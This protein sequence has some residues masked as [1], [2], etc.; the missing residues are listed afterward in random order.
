MTLLCVPIMVQDAPSALDEAQRAKQAGADIIEL[1]VDQVF[2]GSGDEAEFGRIADLVGACPMPVIVTCRS[3]SEGGMYDGPDDARL[4]L[5]EFLGT[6]E[7]RTS[8]GTGSR[9]DRTRHPPR[10]VDVEFAA[11]ERSA[12][13]RQKTHLAVD[14]PHKRRS[15]APGLVLSAHDFGGRP[16]DLTRRVLRMAEIG[17]VDVV[18]IAYRA[19]SLRDNLELLE[20]IGQTGR[21]TI[22]LAMGD[23]GLLSRVLAPKFG[24]FLT[25]AALTPAGATAPGQPAIAEMLGLYRFRSIGKETRVY[26]VIGWPVAHSRSPLVHNVGFGAIGFDGV[27]LPMPIA[28]SDDSPATYAAFKATL[29]E[30]LAFPGLGFRGASVTLPFKEHLVHLAREQGWTIDAASIATGAA[31]TLDVSGGGI[32]VSNTD[33]GALV[34]AIAD[35]RG[36]LEGVRCSLLGAGGVA[37]CAAYGLARAGAVVTVHNRDPRRAQTMAAHINTALE[38]SPGCSPV[39]R[40]TAGLWEGAPIDGCDLIVNGTSVGM[41]GGPPGSPLSAASI[42]RLSPATVVMDT[43]YTPE[44][45]ELLRLAEARGLRTV[46]GVEMFVRQAESQFECWTGI[47]P[48]RGLFRDALATSPGE[49][50]HAR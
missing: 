9:D 50:D 30:L 13:L 38:S 27:Y 41:R 16:G 49:A 5:Y 42:A 1:R 20:L 34:G 46:T 47:A 31:N 2:S 12:N 29:L 14:W 36:P 11:Y 17:A 8:R 6:I 33:V 4:A 32:G 10:Y 19:R 44:K 22:A 15:G 48:P 21:P 25:F 35:A 37:R 40:V 39:G 23:F 45:T 7:P 28:A 26:G 24:A 3:S 18:K 43:V